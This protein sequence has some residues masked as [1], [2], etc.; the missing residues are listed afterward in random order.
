MRRR[1][2]A[3]T[4]PPS[5]TSFGKG[6]RMTGPFPLFDQDPVMGGNHL[7]RRYLQAAHQRPTRSAV[8]QAGGVGGGSE[9]IYLMV[10][11]FKPSPITDGLSAA[12][13]V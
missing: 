3:A 12:A 11:G 1:A 9:R 4:E 7:R 8:G 6:Q 5:G 13:T 2:T 10:K